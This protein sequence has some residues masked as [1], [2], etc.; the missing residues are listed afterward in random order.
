MSKN[1]P[2]PIN[3]QVSAA[4]EGLEEGEHRFIPIPKDLRYFRKYLHYLSTKLE[5]K[6]GA[7]VVGKQLKVKRLPYSSMND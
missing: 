4:M 6:Y 3:K 2:A 5:M 7:K 1:K